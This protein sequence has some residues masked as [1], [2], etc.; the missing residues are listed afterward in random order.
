MIICTLAVFAVL[1]ALLGGEP[2][3][4]SSWPSHG[5][6]DVPAG[7]QTLVFEFSEPM[8]RDRMS[9]TTGNAGAAPEFIGAPAFSADGRTFRIRMRL[10]P[11]LTYVIGANS[12][13]HS[14]FQSERGEPA[15]PVVI[16][17]STVAPS[18]R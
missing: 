15:A 16:R 9:V 18:G 11:G 14:N 8:A 4:V 13:N 2:R 3:L 17:F 5:A 7:E 6:Q 1:P 12:P 10:Q